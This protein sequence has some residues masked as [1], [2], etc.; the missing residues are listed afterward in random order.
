MLFSFFLHIA[1]LE[2][3]SRR[4]QWS[5]SQSCVILATGFNFSQLVVLKKEI[6]FFKLGCLASFLINIAN[7]KK[8]K[9]L[10][11]GCIRSGIGLSLKNFKPRMWQSLRKGKK[12]WGEFLLLQTP[13]VF[14]W[15][16]SFLYDH[17][18]KLVFPL[19]LYFDDFCIFNMTWSFDDFKD[20]FVD[21]PILSRSLDENHIFF[22]RDPLT[23]IT[24]FSRHIDK[25]HVFFL[26]SFDKR[27]STHLL[28]KI[29]FFVTLWLNLL[30]FFFF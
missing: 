14:K 25:N 18:T 16:S 30:L 1:N 21:Y 17:L 6:L 27:P 3:I 15:N 19:L 7:Y 9:I 11:L 29:V 2:A 26:W 4:A 20:F 13:T 28:A 24:N 23:K 22:S 8:F 5:V 12:K 10:S